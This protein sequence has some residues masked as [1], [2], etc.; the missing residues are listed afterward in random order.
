MI[1]R[2]LHN[3]RVRQLKSS[4]PCIWPTK[5]WHCNNTHGF[6]VATT[7]VALI[8]PYFLSLSDVPCAAAGFN[9]AS[10]R[11]L[12]FAISLL[13]YEVLHEC[14]GQA[15]PDWPLNVLSLVKRYYS[16]SLTHV[17]L[18]VHVVSSFTY[19]RNVSSNSAL[20]SY[21]IYCI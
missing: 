12:P 17:C 6:V 16:G 21:H 10:L 2:Q 8:S 11:S 18:S 7:T 5:V 1:V 9:E 15:K 4:L 14:Q 19:K 13:I 20:L 3:Q